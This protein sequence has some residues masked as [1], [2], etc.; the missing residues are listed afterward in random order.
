M[1]EVLIFILGFT[2]GTIG[3]T[4]AAYLGGH[5]VIRTYMELTQPHYELPNKVEEDTTNTTQ[6]E[7]YDWGEYEGYL[8]P[9]IGDDGG[10]P[11]A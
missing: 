6:S 3:T 9:P 11:E 2:L 10:D 8:A 7:S 4:I 1:H 5:L